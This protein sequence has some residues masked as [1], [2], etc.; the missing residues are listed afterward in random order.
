VKEAVFF[1]Q[2]GHGVLLALVEPA[3]Q[4]GQEH[5][6]GQRVGTAGESISPTSQ[7]FEDLRS[8]NET[9]RGRVKRV[10]VWALVC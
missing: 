2:V 10:V 3:D 6:E 9:L 8:S 7:G 4:R 5:A 1:Y